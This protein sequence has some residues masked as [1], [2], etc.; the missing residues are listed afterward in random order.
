MRERR[1]REGERHLF[2]AAFDDDILRERGCRIGKG[3]HVVLNEL[4]NRKWKE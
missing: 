3:I 1:E 2:G 4:I